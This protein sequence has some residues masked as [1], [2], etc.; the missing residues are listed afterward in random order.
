ML[1]WI[2]PRYLV[3]FTLWLR[4]VLDVSWFSPKHVG[5]V[6]SLAL[7]G[8]VLSWKQYL[9]TSSSLQLSCLRVWFECVRSVPEKA[10]SLWYFSP[11]EA[12]VEETGHCFL[13][14]VDAIAVQAAFLWCFQSRLCRR[15]AFAHLLSFC[16]SHRRPG[17]AGGVRRWLP[18]LPSKT[19]I[20]SCFLANCH[21]DLLPPR[22]E[23][24]GHAQGKPHGSSFTRCLS[25]FQA[26]RVDC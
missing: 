10:V 22:V 3:F 21:P 19:I 11:A 13:K 20:S 18:A 1:E 24:G 2:W 5:C 16:H 12:A 23:G 9:V 25:R 7:Y 14:M 6:C 26:K 4:H 17:A 15:L 8:H